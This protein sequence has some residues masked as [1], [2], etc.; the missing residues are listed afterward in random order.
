V[1]GLYLS[2]YVKL[3]LGHLDEL[4]SWAIEVSFGNSSNDR[5]DSFFIVQFDIYFPVIFLQFQLFTGL[6]PFCLH[7]HHIAE[8][9]AVF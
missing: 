9:L 2:H 4:I 3:M 8:T 1:N 5:F 7:F 6:L